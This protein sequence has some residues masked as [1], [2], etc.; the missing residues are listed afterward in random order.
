MRCS[1]TFTQ[2]GLGFGYLAAIGIARFRD[3]SFASR[4]Q[5]VS[6]QLLR[7]TRDSFTLGRGLAI[8]AFFTL[9]V[10]VP[11]EN[12]LDVFNEAMDHSLACGDKYFFLF[13]AGCLALS[14]LYLGANMVETESSCEFSAEGFG[15][16]STDTRGGVLL[17]AV[18]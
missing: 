8:S 16:W 2:S 7:R 11:L 17:T 15:D 5:D 1:G 3:L 10:L 14:R 13:S 6:E 4:M 12:L 18:R 9:H